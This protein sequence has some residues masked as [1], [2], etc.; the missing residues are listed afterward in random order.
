M[1]VR[2]Q[3]QELSTKENVPTATRMLNE[4]TPDEL[5]TLDVRLFNYKGVPLGALRIVEEGDADDIVTKMR[6]LIE[7]TNWKPLAETL[8]KKLD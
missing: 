4:F 8:A 5:E 1:D 7:T 6:E 3:L 2:A